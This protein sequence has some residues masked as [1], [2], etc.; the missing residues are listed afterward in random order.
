M[1]TSFSSV[2]TVAWA[3]NAPGAPTSVQV[4]PVVTSGEGG[5]VALRIDGID[6]E[7][8]G[9]L[10][11]TSPAGE[12]V[13]VPVRRGDS[14]VDV[15][16]YRVGSNVSSPIT[17]TPYS[18]F[19]LP[20][21]SGGD[22]S[23]A[24][25]T[26]WG[27]GIGAPTGLALSLTS[28]SDGGGTSTITAQGTAQLNGDGSELRFGIVREGDRCTPT[29][30]GD[31]ATFAGLP[32]GDEY[33]FTMCVESWFD[34]TLYGEATTTAS[35]RA[36]QTGQAPQG[37]TFS[38]DATP[39][40]GSDRADWIVRAAPTSTERI[41]N[42]NRIEFAGLPSTVFGRDPLIQVRYVHEVWETATAWAPVTPQAGSA[43]YQVQ[44]RWGVD[45]CVG[46]ATLV[47]SG[48]S[49]SDAAGGKAA[50]TFGNAGLRYFDASGA[51][52]AHAA[53]SWAVPVGA[54]RVEG[55]TVSVD[56]SAQ[57]WGLS[58]ANAT[59]SAS[60]DPNLAPPSP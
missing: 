29:A 31:T 5:V 15:Q 6:P 2:R 11:I 19:D 34:D 46:G 37:Y 24:A 53:D 35:A 55:I 10:E 44:A 50:I 20:P 39:E 9:S 13:Q 38:V 40:V 51:V 49:S 18:R 16:G 45:S 30:G 52:L 23:G 41:P 57:G 47:T 33:A 3:Y 25:A 54:V 60:C 32:D 21:G 17:I 28:A 59:F 26:V 48:D 14:S 58:S 12:S 42:R 43:P 7:T 22:S 56:W 1:G 8:T 4:R 36:Q 27:N